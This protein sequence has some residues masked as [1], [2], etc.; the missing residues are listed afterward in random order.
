[1]SEFDT[2]NSEQKGEADKKPF[3]ESRIPLGPNLDVTKTGLDRQ[4][5]QSERGQRLHQM[6]LRGKSS[7][8]GETVAPQ[9]NADVASTDTQTA[10][11]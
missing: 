1:M 3:L 5:E 6:G 8:S 11:G 7:M 2:S 4:I 10:E 9:D